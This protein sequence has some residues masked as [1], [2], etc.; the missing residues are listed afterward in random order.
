M[1]SGVKEI[2]TFHLFVEKEVREVRGGREKQ[3]R[4]ERERKVGLKKDVISRF[5]SCLKATFLSL[6]L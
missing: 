1:R 3:E 5:I 4:R 2:V 6:F